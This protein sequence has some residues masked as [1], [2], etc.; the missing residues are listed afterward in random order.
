MANYIITDATQGWEIKV[1]STQQEAEE[2]FDK[3]DGNVCVWLNGVDITEYIITGEEIPVDAE[4][5]VIYTD[6]KDNEIALTDD[7][8]KY[9]KAT[10]EKALY[11]TGINIPVY[12]SNHERLNGKHSEALGIHWKSIDGKQEFIT[13]DTFFIHDCYRTEVE[14]WKYN[15]EEETLIGCICHELA[16]IKY[17]R[18]TKYHTAL[19]E[20]YKAMC[21]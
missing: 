3:Y 4:I 8:I 18:H 7:E 19:T 16:H 6:Y 10:A 15:I 5:S 2:M 20:E 17:R 14:G 11:K 9:F 1:V 21:A 12:P 13:I